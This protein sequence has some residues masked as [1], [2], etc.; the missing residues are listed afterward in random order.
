MQA[1]EHL[2]PHMQ[3]RVLVAPAQSL[4]G[5]DRVTGQA[6][7][8]PELPGLHDHHHQ[9][10][11][12]AS[13]TTSALNSRAQQ[14]GRSSQGREDA[15]ITRQWLQVVAAGWDKEVSVWEDKGERNNSDHRFYQGHK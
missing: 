15:I 5:S 6:Q 3:C 10:P 2:S 7:C 8:Q 13:G 9:S 1:A 14:T 12:S 4:A 11:Y